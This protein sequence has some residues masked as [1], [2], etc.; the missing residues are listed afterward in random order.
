MTTTQ[1][2][3]TL[4]HNASPSQRTEIGPIR[5][6]VYV[7]LWGMVLSYPFRL[8]FLKICSIFPFV[9]STTVAS[10]A[11]LLEGITGEPRR[12][13]SR[14]PTSCIWDSDKTSPTRTSLRRGTVRRS[15]GATRYFLPAIEA[16]TYWLGCERMRASAWEVDEGVCMLV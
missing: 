4:G 9:C 10:T 2:C 13:Y 12:V 7:C 14:E 3:Q 15:F 11:M 16:I 6:R 1:N 8:F 5:S